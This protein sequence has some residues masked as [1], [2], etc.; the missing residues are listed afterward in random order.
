M[1]A[2]SSTTK[3][4]RVI[5]DDDYINCVLR[6]TKD[7][8]AIGPLFEKA[9]DC[10]IYTISF[11]K[12]TNPTFFSLWSKLSSVMLYLGES[13]TPFI[14]MERPLADLEAHYFRMGEWTDEYETLK[15]TLATKCDECAIANI[16]ADINRLVSV[17]SQKEKRR[18]LLATKIQSRKRAHVQLEFPVNFAPKHI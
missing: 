3:R 13:D 12:S 10:P 2:S 8:V 15:E 1:A 17:I 6:G 4:Q 16:D 9:E 18:E 5:N 14:D 7:N 11:L